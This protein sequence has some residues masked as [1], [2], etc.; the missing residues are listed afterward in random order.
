MHAVP[1]AKSECQWNGKDGIKGK[2]IKVSYVRVAL[3]FGA[4]CVTTVTSSGDFML[5]R[6]ALALPARNTDPARHR[7]AG[8]FIKNCSLVLTVYK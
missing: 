8:R 7:R 6:P 1:A 3:P 5:A 2:T 4:F